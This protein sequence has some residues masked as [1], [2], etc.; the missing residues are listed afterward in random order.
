MPPPPDPTNDQC[1][2]VDIYDAPAPGGNGTLASATPLTLT[3]PMAAALCYADDVD[4][5][6]FT[7]LAGQGVTIDL[8]IRPEGYSLTLYDPGGASIPVSCATARC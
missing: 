4:M 3:V 2:F 8:P 1:G 5:Y 7:G 6:A